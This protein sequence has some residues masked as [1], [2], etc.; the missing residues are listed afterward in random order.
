MNLVKIIN[1]IKCF[2]ISNLIQMNRFVDVQFYL[3]TINFASNH[4]SSSL[5]L[6]IMNNVSIIIHT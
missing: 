6:N 2:M 4:G 5:Q 3:T 1:I